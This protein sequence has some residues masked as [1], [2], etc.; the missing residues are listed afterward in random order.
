VN[1]PA[2]EDDPDRLTPP[3]ARQLFF[4]LNTFLF[5]ERGAGSQSLQG[6][7][8]RALLFAMLIF[9]I[10][11][12]FLSLPPARRPEA[13]RDLAPPSASHSAPLA[14]ART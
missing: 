3:E 4:P 8:W 14:G 11:E 6:E 10:G 5:E 7:I 1:R 2:A 12:S 9:L 13:V